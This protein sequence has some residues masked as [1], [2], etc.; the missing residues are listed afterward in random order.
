MFVLSLVLQVITDVLL[1]GGVGALIFYFINKW[2]FVAEEQSNV[3]ET[4]TKHENVDQPAKPIVNGTPVSKA[5]PINICLSDENEQ[6]RIYGNYNVP[7]SDISL[8]EEPENQP[9]KPA[10]IAPKPSTTVV[11]PV[12]NKQKIKY[13]SNCGQIIDPISK[14]CRGCGKQYF[15]GISAKTVLAILTCVLSIASIAGNIALCISNVDLREN[16]SS[17]EKTNASLKEKNE[18]LKEENEQY[19]DYWVESFNEIAFYDEYVVF[20]EDDGTNL[21][22]KYDC[23]KFTGDSFW[24]FN[25]DAAK[26]EGYKPCSRCCD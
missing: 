18:G 12:S 8:K 1:I 16:I 6:P 7:G 4:V 13:C 3:E 25:V 19:Y 20:V 14:K 21:Y 2:I 26:D 24:A 10:P 9:N 17:L 23:S 11:P 22:H 5:Q 15:K